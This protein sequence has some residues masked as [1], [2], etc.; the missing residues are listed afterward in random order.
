[1]RTLTRLWSGSSTSGSSCR[2]RRP[3]RKRWYPSRRKAEPRAPAF[4]AAARFLGGCSSRPVAGRESYGL[5]DAGRILVNHDLGMRKGAAQ[6]G[7]D[8]VRYLMRVQQVHRPVHLDMQLNERGRA[9]D[10]G[11]D[12]VDRGDLGVALGDGADPG[13]LIVRQFA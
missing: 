10:A 1:M 9:G 11:A 7:L 4:G 12:V 13:A 6:P 5:L 3:L 2:C 8:R